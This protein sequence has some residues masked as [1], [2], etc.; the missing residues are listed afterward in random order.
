MRYSKRFLPGIWSGSMIHLRNKFIPHLLL[1]CRSSSKSK[2]GKVWMRIHIFFQDVIL[3][4]LDS[5]ETIKDGGNIPDNFV[6]LYSRLLTVLT[7]KLEQGRRI[8]IISNF[9]I[10]SHN[11]RIFYAVYP[12]SKNNKWKLSAVFTRVHVLAVNLHSSMLF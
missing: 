1:E 4:A 11:C 2:T 12:N 8:I 3:E 10:Y 7:V 5:L 9:Y 6:L